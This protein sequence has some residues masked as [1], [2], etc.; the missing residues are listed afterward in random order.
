MHL[1]KSGVNANMKQDKDVRK[2]EP[3]DDEFK[4]VTMSILVGGKWFFQSKYW[5]TKP[6]K[7][8][9]YIDHGNDRE[10]AFQFHARMEE[11]YKLDPAQ[12]KLSAHN[13]QL[14]AC[15][16]LPPSDEP[17]PERHRGDVVTTQS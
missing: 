13:G 7:A 10:E 12:F 5:D 8:W 6:P 11:A 16:E 17:A 15:D 9:A 14:L 2:F 4:V 3:P 1:K